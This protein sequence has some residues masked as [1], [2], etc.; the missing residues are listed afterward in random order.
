MGA[1]A[2]WVAGRNAPDEHAIGA[3][4]E[5]IAHRG[6]D[7]G[8]YALQSESGHRVVIGQ[9]IFDEESG[10]AVALDGALA[11]RAE[12]LAQL[13]PRGYRFENGIAA[14]ILLRAYE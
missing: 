9:A 4:L 11:N 7:G 1:L 2:G 14:E 12:L 8:V 6:A 10:I 13:A 3:M 5:A